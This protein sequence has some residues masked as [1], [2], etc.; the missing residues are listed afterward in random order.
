MTAPEER[1]ELISLISEATL[2]GAR[3][4]HACNIL[5]LSARTIQRWQRGDLTR[6]TG[7]RYGTMSRATSF[8]STNAPSC[9]R[10][11]IRLNSVICRQ[12]RSCRDWQTSNAISPP[13]RRST[14]Y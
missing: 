2:A 14:G 6:W 7:A 3:Q 8:L 10:S 9:W 12:A 4:A 11:R 13:N 1:K 5:G